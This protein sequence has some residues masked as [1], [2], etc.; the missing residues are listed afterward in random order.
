MA[1]RLDRVLQEMGLSQNES[2]VFLALNSLGPAA[3]SQ[4]ARAGKVKRSTTY[5]VLEQ[6]VERGVYS[7]RG[8]H[9]K[10]KS[11]SPTEK[12]SR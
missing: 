12:K 5:F 9:L 6:L 8:L 10:S 7:C 11:R 3:A 2:L 4:V 1:I